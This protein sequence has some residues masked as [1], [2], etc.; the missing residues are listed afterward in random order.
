MH[1]QYD[2][3]CPNSQ[4]PPHFPPKRSNRKSLVPSDLI[5][6]ISVFECVVQ[7]GEGGEDAELFANDSDTFVCNPAADTRESGEPSGGVSA[8]HGTLQPALSSACLGL[9]LGERRTF[10]VRPSDVSHPSPQRD[11]GLVVTVPTGG[12][13]VNVGMLA[14]IPFQGEMR[15]CIVKSVRYSHFHNLASSVFPT[16]HFLV[17]SGSSPFAESL[18]TSPIIHKCSVLCSNQTRII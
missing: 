10:L 15:L 11:P 4:S 17:G 18:S 2:T 16:R 12:A 7:V 3:Q 9:S 1:F 8:A 6:C 13:K 5:G 14:K